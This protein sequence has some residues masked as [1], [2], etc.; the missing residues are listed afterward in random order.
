MALS[1]L[2]TDGLILDDIALRDTS[3]QPFRLAS[4]KGKPVVLSLIYTS[5]HHVCPMITRNVKETVEIG[6]EALGNDAFSVVTVGF[7]WQVDTPDRMRMYASGHGI[8][9]TV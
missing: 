1:N 9:N 3:G 8:A 2:R 5:C 7:D 6:R 4:L